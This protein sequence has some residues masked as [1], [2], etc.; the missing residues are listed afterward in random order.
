MQVRMRQGRWTV[1]AA[2]VA[3]MT[4]AVIGASYWY[5]VE[6]A[7]AVKV[8]WRGDVT[9]AQRSDL[10]RRYRLVAPIAMDGRTVTYNALDTSAANLEALVGDAAVEDTGDIDRMRFTI[11]PDVPYGTR[12]MWAADRVPVLREPGVIPVMV[13]VCAI[14]IG[15]AAVRRERRL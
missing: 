6:P 4:M 15:L 5:T 7:P 10:E 13:G 11:A 2:A 14:V 3:V 9:E 8:R 12:W 1:M